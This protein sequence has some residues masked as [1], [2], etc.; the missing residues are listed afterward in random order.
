M[1]HQ[2][3][4]PDNI[5]IDSTGTVKIIDFDSMK[6]AGIMEITTSVERNNL[7]GTAQYTA[8]EY[9][10]GESGSS[11]SDI[12]SLGVITYQ[13]LTSKLP[14]GAEVAKLRTKAAQNKLNYNSALDTD[15]SIPSGSM[16]HCERQ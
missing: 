11:L 1:L 10:L 16:R 8:A 9:F 14:Y 4:R 13:M 2:D 15:R 12:F 7:L 5:M 3:L 6:V